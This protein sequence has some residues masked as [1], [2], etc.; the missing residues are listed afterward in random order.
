MATSSVDADARR[1]SLPRPPQGAGGGGARQVRSRP[2]WGRLGLRGLAL[3][4]LGC[5]V[6][7]PIVALVIRG[8]SHGL[9]PLKDAFGAPGAWQAIQLTLILAG[10][11]ALI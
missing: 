7:L 1:S 11:T 4:Y 3:F 6:G 8:Y 5:L 9:G 10:L 2:P